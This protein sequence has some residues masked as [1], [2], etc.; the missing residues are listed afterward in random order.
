M[1]I[2]LSKI[3]KR[4]TTTKINLSRTLGLSGLSEIIS[5]KEKEKEEKEKEE[6]K[7]IDIRTLKTGGQYIYA[8]PETKYEDLQRTTRASGSLETEE[9]KERDHVIPVSL[10]GTSDD[11]NLQYLE[12]KRTILQRIFDK[13]A[14]AKNRQE[15]KMLVELQNIN[16]YKSGKIGINEARTNVLNWNNQPESKYKT[17]AE[18]FIETSKEMFK[19][20]VGGLFGSMARLVLPESLE[21]KLGLVGKSKKGD[22]LFPISEETKEREIDKA[23]QDAER[24]LGVSRVEE[25][26]KGL[27]RG[28]E[29]LAGTTTGNLMNWLGENIKEN[30]SL[31]E[32]VNNYFGAKPASI[33]GKIGL[34]I[35]EKVPIGEK[36]K[37]LSKADTTQRFYEIIGD[38]MQKGGNKIYNYTQEATQK[39]WEVE[40]PYLKNKT[41]FNDPK[42]VKIF[43]S[44]GEALPSLGVATAVTIATGNPY[45]G[46]SILGMSQGADTYRNL[47]EKGATVGRAN[48]FGAL[49]T[50]GTTVLEQIPLEKIIGG[51]VGMSI[52]QEGAEEGLQQ[53]WTNLVNIWGGD[54]TREWKDGVMESILLGGA[55]GGLVGGFMK[56][57]VFRNLNALEKEAKDAGVTN[58]Q[59]DEVKKQLTGVII[60]NA[61]KIEPILQEQ[62]RIPATQQEIDKITQD[63]QALPSMSEIAETVKEIVSARPEPLAEEAE[64]LRGTKG[65]TAEDIQK[66]YPN[67]KLTKDVPAKDVYGNKVVIPEGEKLTPYEMKDGKILLQ[68][69]QTYLVSKNQ[70]QN[71]KGQSVG[72]EAKPFAPELA[73]TEETIKGAGKWEGDE[74]VADGQTVANLIKNDDGTWSYESDLSEGSETFKTRREAMESVVE[75]ITDPYADTGTKYSSYQL[76]EGKNYK[77]ILIKAPNKAELDIKSRQAELDTI[78]NRLYGKPYGELYR[79]DNAVEKMD[80]VSDL[81]KQEISNNFKSSHWDEPNVISHLRMNDRTYKGKKVSFMEELQSDWAREGRDKGFSAD[82]ALEWKKQS[83]GSLLS[84][85]GVRTFK[86][87]PEGDKFYVYEEKGRLGQTQPTI[88]KAKKEAQRVVGEGIPNNP[89]LKN[90]TEMS[91]KRALQDAVANNSDYFAWINGEQTSA[92]YNLSTQVDGVKWKTKPDGKVIALT[93][94]GSADLIVGIDKKGVVTKSEMDNTWVGKK[95][96]EV[97][98]KG[99]ADKIMSKEEGTL[100]GEGLK[101]GGEW[102]SNLY[103]RQ[104]KNIVEKLTGQKVEMLDMGLP[105]DAKNDGFGLYTENSYGNLE[106]QGDIDTFSD[107]LEVGNIVGKS[108]QNPYIVTK[109]LGNDNFQ[110]VKKSSLEKA[111]PEFQKDIK[112]FQETG[113]LS[114]NIKPFILQASETFDISTPK[115]TQQG[116]K[117]TPEVKNKIKGIAP[118]IK[119]SG[120]MFEE[121][122]PTPQVKQDPLIQEAKKYKTAEEFVKAQPKVYHGGADLKEIKD[123]KKPGE[124][125]FTTDPEYALG[126]SGAKGELTEAVPNLKKPFIYDAKNE[127]MATQKIKE[128]INKND[129]DPAKN[130]YSDYDGMIIK[131]IYKTDGDWYVPFKK[132]AIK[133]KSQLTDIWNEANKGGV[134]DNLIS[135]AKKYKSADG[136]DTTQFKLEKAIQVRDNYA[137]ANKSFLTPEATD[138]TL[139]IAGRKN[140]RLKR[141]DEVMDKYTKLSD[142]VDF[143]QNK[144]DNIKNKKLYEAEAPAREKIA[145]YTFKLGDKI[146]TGNA[147]EYSTAKIIKVNK[148]SY[149]F[150]YKNGD[151]G[152]MDKKLMNRWNQDEI[153]TK[154]TD[155]RNKAQEAKPKLPTVDKV[156]D[157][158]AITKEKPITQDFSKH[159]ERIKDKSGFDSLGVEFDKITLKGEVKK[160]YD[161]I[162]RNPEKAMRIAYGFDTTGSEIK[163]QAIRQSLIASLLEQG[164]KSQAQEIARKVTKKFTEAAQVLNLAKTDLGDEPTITRNI[165]QARLQRIGEKAGNIDPNKALIEGEKVVKER[166]NKV[167]KEVNKTQAEMTETTLQEI[168]NLIDSLIC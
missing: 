140:P 22:M 58:E 79:L 91:V 7:K 43:S 84:E 45:A 16:D 37:P 136:I 21:R 6:K 158:K 164:K 60:E 54:K 128:I 131:N 119:T 100:S 108:G 151:V 149:K 153:E 28:A 98:G 121:K 142:K 64:I 107:G 86:I 12:S 103:D 77:E 101:F 53:V 47:R 146:N 117:L 24:G 126:F 120:K 105:I 99:L 88:E 139:N 44:L 96:D 78:S 72:G 70:F 67:I 31:Q 73:G 106:W 113:K 39:G 29:S 109:V 144:V 152:S 51:K 132:E 156:K 61:N 14:S 71:I 94:K 92:R 46:A 160:A 75:E 116:I 19:E 148:N 76:P 90:W 9:D 87:K 95:L 168:D 18:S 33:L 74:Y 1:P 68:D 115:T 23:Q 30:K 122:K 36:K 13:P 97:L 35:L 42:G 15:G 150:E 167:A 138:F 34:E 83:D 20:T 163:N 141:M 5:R 162:Q 114:E 80:K 57:P 81:A 127:K 137:E 66:T 112:V 10:G 104:V 125:L 133:T 134:T 25:S 165:T 157:V 155:I 118:E 52:L 11:P 27:V 69:G 65:M 93:P 4:R 89:L 50:I 62:L 8:K 40:H 38:T 48:V 161:Y 32:S 85:V 166:T 3:L 59:I 130:I 159:Y 49:D 17:Y 26:I 102:A 2:N 145:D 111:L 154:L 124:L 41:I 55:S 82:V 123:I 110:A 143:W 129:L 147:G 135:E 56:L 63:T